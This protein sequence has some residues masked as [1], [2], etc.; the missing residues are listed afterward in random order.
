VLGTEAGGFGGW[1][2]VGTG[3]GVWAAGSGDLGGW[4]GVGTCEG[5][6]G[7]G[8]GDFG[9]SGKG[10]G[11]P[12]PCGPRGTRGCDGF[13]PLEPGWLAPT[14]PGRSCGDGDPDTPGT[15]GFGSCGAFGTALAGLAE[16][17]MAALATINVTTNFGVS[18]A[19]FL[20]F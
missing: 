16:A 13:K 10:L 7:P 12:A 17:L 9:D 3:E 20:A 18:G 19:L 4:G 5:M 2:G 6:W 11:T 1:G 15:V 8:S 14:G